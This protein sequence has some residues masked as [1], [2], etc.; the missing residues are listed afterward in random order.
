[1]IDELGGNAG[2]LKTLADQPGIFFVDLL[3]SGLR[4]GG[5]R[6]RLQPVRRGAPQEKGEEDSK[7]H[8]VQ[9]YATRRTKSHGPDFRTHSLGGDS[10]TPAELTW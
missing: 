9:A 2:I 8:S 10:R 1:V 7:E 4:R 3:R 5:P 6:L